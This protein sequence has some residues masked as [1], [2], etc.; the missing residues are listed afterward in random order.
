MHR[1]RAM[2]VNLGKGFFLD[3]RDH[4]FKSLRPRGIEHQQRKPSVARDQPDAFV[5]ELCMLSQCC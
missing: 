4:D 3:C 1:R 2:R 5:L